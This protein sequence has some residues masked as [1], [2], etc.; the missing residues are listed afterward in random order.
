[1]IAVGARGTARRNDARIL[2]ESHQLSHAR[3]LATTT[4]WKCDEADAPGKNVGL[5]TVTSSRVTSSRVTIHESGGRVTRSRE[6]C[7][8]E[9]LVQLVATQYRN[10]QVLDTAA[11]L[12]IIVPYLPL[13]VIQAEFSMLLVGS[14]RR[15]SG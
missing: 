4:A 13:V 3:A 10:P 15:F 5:D 9:W 11:H 8:R 12:L 14:Y 1:M 6:R 7:S 2:L